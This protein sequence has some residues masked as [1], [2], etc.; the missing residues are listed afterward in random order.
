MSLIA[1][2]SRCARRE[3]LDST[4]EE[5]A[6]TAFERRLRE[7]G[8]PSDIRSDNGVP[9]APSRAPTPCLNSQS[10]RSGG[11]GSASP[12]SA[13]SPA[14]RSRTA[15][16][17]TCTSTRPPGFNTL[18]QQERFDAF[19]QEFDAERPHEALDMKRPAIMACPN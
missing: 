5:T 8:L 13:S 18:Q 17:N 14:T 2:R 12:S 1:L 3:A 6:L 4:R 10:S 7:R 15:A 11:S 19:V 9:F 16:A